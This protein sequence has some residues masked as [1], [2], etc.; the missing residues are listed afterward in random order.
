MT[1][2]HHPPLGVP[3]L[4]A[5]GLGLP[6]LTHAEADTLPGSDAR[7]FL[8]DNS[9]Q[10]RAQIDALRLRQLQR[11][12]QVLRPLPPLQVALPDTCLAIH[13]LRLSGVTLLD[14]AALAT[15]HIPD[16][17][18]FS[19]QTLVRVLHALNALYLARG[20]I[21]ARIL[22][23][24][25]DGVMTL[26]VI[27]G[28]VDRIDGIDAGPA[29]ISLFPG[30]LGK[31]LNLRD[32]EQGLDQA[33]RLQSRQMHAEVVP[34]ALPGSSTLSL[35]DQPS[36]PWAG[37]VALDN[38]GYD[39]TG[40]HSAGLSVSRDN[41][42]GH[43][44][45][46]SFSLERSLGHARFSHR[47]SVFYSLP[48]GYWSLSAFAARSEY[49]NPQKLVFNTVDLS[50]SSSQL[51]GRVDRVM[52]RS[53]TRIDSLHLSVSHKRVRNFFLGNLQQISS[54]TLTVLELGLSR[55]RL[56][57]GGS[58]S[59]D[60]SLEQGMPWLGAQR[61]W[62][63]AQYAG[64]PQAQFSKLRLH[65]GLHNS[66]GRLTL[67][68]RF[69]WQASRQRL[70]AIEQLE[71]ADN[72]QVRG[73]RH[74]SLAGEV[75][76]AWHNTVSYRHQFARMS[77]SPR[78]ALDLGQVLQRESARSQQRLSGGGV[79]LLLSQAGGS[80]DLEYSR[81]LQRPALFV[82]ESRQLLAKLSWQF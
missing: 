59:L 58:W 37:S 14:A 39:A 70:P 76:W 51:G 75:G 62:R 15:I 45:F 3:L 17:A 67:S 47:G 13:A 66:L 69:S 73:F 18:C 7:Y 20:W 53:Q 30:M 78:L 43:F 60:A 26:R 21:S 55:L 5:V 24:T 2:H 52:A 82:R 74:N 54:P 1:R 28:R 4:M 10:I 8:Q 25:R 79:G 49:L 71:L 68:S 81:P 19:H 16:E 41:P 65:A 33:N 38:R 11:D 57:A 32:L 44:D 40:R 22:P 63:S 50:G 48:Y 6:D 29:S 12:E 35:S 9:E 80:L 64:L 36:S 61:D 34:G 72:T 46:V 27:E 77:V 42:T 23:E 56:L 31:P